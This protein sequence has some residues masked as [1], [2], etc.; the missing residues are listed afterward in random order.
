MPV[1]LKS[2][3]VPAVPIKNFYNDLIKAIG[4]QLTSGLLAA[5]KA[6]EYERLKTYWQI[7]RE[8]QSAVERSGGTL[9][10]GEGL[11]RQISRDIERTIDLALTIDT[12]GRTVQFYKNYPAFPQG[13]PLTFTHYLVLQRISDAKLRARMEKTAIRRNITVPELK[14][15]LTRLSLEGSGAVRPPRRLKIDRGEPYVYYLRPETDL[16]EARTMRIDC[17]F[18]INWDLPADN[19]VPDHARVVRSDKKDGRY[20]LSLYKEGKALLY[21]YA[22]QILEVVDGDTIH[23]RID[24]GFG[25]GLYD[26]LRLKWL[27]APELT[28]APGRLAKS[29]LTDYLSKCPYVVLRTT[30]EEKFG[31]WLADIFTIPNCTNPYKIAAEG[32][33]LNQLLLDK[34]LAEVYQ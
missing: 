25:I 33:Y 15:E 5:Q 13:T 23:A 4:V 16:S 30:R 28:T 12:L 7:G 21:T 14:N 18:K 2:T 1:T 29:F 17:G 20:S 22:A 8:I 6:V 3:A 31:R 19:P 34:G 11:Y 27:N 26:H 24:V 9:R 32:E 10:L